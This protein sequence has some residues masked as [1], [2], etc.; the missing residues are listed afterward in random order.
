LGINMSSHLLIEQDLVIASEG[1][2]VNVK[3]TT[4]ATSKTTGTMITA[5]GRSC[6]L[7]DWVGGDQHVEG[8]IYGPK[9]RITPE[10]GIAIKLTNKTGAPSVK[11][12]VVAPYSAT[13]VD[14][15]VKKIVVDEP[16]PIGVFYESDIADGAEAW[17]VIAGIAEVYF[18]G[19]TT[20]GHIAR[21]FITGDAG[22][23]AGQ[24][25]SEAVPTSPFATDKHF[26]EIGHLLASRTGAGLAKTAVHFN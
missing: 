5:G 14:N 15:A 9:V 21:G 2:K 1:Y 13:A 7:D 16:D 8:S 19:N 26:Y 17:I 23:V 12:E 6:Q 10:G 22:Y 20:R 25:L 4:N 11:G 3:S 24:A 18:I